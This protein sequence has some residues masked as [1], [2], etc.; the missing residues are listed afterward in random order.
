[1][2]KICP[3]C[4]TSCPDTQAFCPSC[5]AQLPAAQPSYG[6]R[7]PQGQQPYGQQPPYGQPP[8]GQQPYGPGLGM[9]WYKF[10]IYFVLFVAAL[11]YLG[12]G[13]SAFTSNNL[14][15][16][17]VFFGVPLDLTSAFHAYYSTLR[18]IDILYGIVLIAMAAGAIYVRMQ[19][20][21]FRANGPKLFLCLWAA[22]TVV[23]MIHDMAVLA[24]VTRADAN[25]LLS[26]S[27]ATII[28]QLIGMGIYIVLN[29]IYF[30]KRAHLFVN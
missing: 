25:A 26:P 10:L 27:V 18:I 15:F 7:P 12:I 9:K 1:M 24:I 29:N 2:P 30:K 22:V 13:I 28:G 16:S 19:L 6:Q 14:Y 4:G 23:Q 3:R 11:G 20:A 5:G 8:Y 21:A 17:N